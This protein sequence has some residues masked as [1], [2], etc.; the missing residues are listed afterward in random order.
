M[1][2]IV[3]SMVELIQENQRTLNE[4]KKQDDEVCRVH[5]ES[6]RGIELVRR[7]EEKQR[8]ESQEKHIL[9]SHYGNPYVTLLLCIEAVLH[10]VKLTISIEDIA[11]GLNKAIVKMVNLALEERGMDR[12]IQFCNQLTNAEIE[13]MDI[14]RVVCLGNSNTYE[15]F[16]KMETKEVEYVPLFNVVVYYDDGK[17]E[18]LVRNMVEYAKKNFYEIEVFDETDDFEEVLYEITE[19]Q[20]QYGAV[21]LS[22]D[23]NKQEKFKSQVK[24]KIVC[25]NENLFKKFELEIPRE[26]FTKKVDFLWKV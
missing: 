5:F 1:K 6:S 14:E 17:Y 7:Y 20:Q 15:R 21:I 13:K 22:M 12:Q 3:S 19:T 24:A 18:E 4:L 10:R 16:R 2:K 25:V 26:I 8:Q 11:Y 23:A 9:V